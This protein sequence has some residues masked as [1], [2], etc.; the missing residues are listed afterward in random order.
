MKKQNKKMKKKMNKNNENNKNMVCI[1]LAYSENFL[2]IQKHLIMNTLKIFQ[3][4]I[5]SRF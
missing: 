3:Y 1:F 5:F 2:T 4:R